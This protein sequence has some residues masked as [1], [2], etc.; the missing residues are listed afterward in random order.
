M[1]LQGSVGLHRRRAVADGVR[2]GRFIGTRVG[3]AA[4]ARWQRVAVRAAVR[5]VRRGPR[6]LGARRRPGGRRR[7]RAAPAG[8]PGPRAAWTPGSGAALSVVIALGLAWLAGAV[9]LQAPRPR[10]T[11]AAPSS[12]RRSCA[13]ST[14]CC[15]QRRDPPRAGAL[16]PVPVRRRARRRR[17][18]RRPREDR[19]RPRRQARRRR[20]GEGARIACGLGVEGS[21]WIAR[22]R[23]GRD[24]RARRRGRGRH[25]RAAARRRARACDAQ[26][27]AFDPT[28]DIAVLRVNGLGGRALPL[29]P[30]APP[31]RAGGGAGLPAQ[32]AVRRARRPGSAPPSRCSAR[33]PTGAGR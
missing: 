8:A 26:A 22:P 9:V 11:C 1:A 4:A 16:R 29:A 12:A 31:G 6:G 32:R 13:G 21:G 33:T 23:G 17:C 20:R 14:T 24:Q 27:V 25:R 18:P 2:R 28:N 30:Q 3:A 10:A 15:R 7:A 19:P 5:P